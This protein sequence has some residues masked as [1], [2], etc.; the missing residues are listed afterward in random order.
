M[1]KNI[2]RMSLKVLSTDRKVFK[3]SIPTLLGVLVTFSAKSG[4]FSAETCEKMPKEAKKE[5]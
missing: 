1:S 3:E 4:P 2:G 5:A